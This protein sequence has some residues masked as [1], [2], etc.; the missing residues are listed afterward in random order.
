MQTLDDLFAIIGENGS[1]LTPNE[2]AQIIQILSIAGSSAQGYSLSG[3]FEFFFCEEVGLEGFDNTTPPIKSWED[4]EE[5]F[6]ITLSPFA[7]WEA[8]SRIA[9]AHSTTLLVPF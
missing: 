1:R 7:C 8:I 6:H 5:V 2:K 9:L 4:F 3:I